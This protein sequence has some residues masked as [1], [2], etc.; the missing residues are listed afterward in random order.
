MSTYY[1]AT[2]ARYV[3]VE[4]ENELDARG[5]GQAALHDLYHDLRERLGKE[6][7]INIKIV[8]LATED[9]IKLG[10]WHEQKV[11]QESRQTGT[12]QTARELL[13]EPLVDPVAQDKTDWTPMSVP[14]RENADGT[15]TPT[16]WFAFKRATRQSVEF[17]SFEEA[18][19]FCFHPD[20]QR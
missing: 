1:V 10:R 7:P 19:A 15:E 8:R 18:A 5:R 4:A 12:Q 16:A 3:L 17:T 6:V 9:E 13:G 2:L 14:G 20:N 11:A